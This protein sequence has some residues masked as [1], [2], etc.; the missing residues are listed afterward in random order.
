MEVVTGTFDPPKPLANKS[1]YDTQRLKAALKYTDCTLRHQERKLSPVGMH[2]LRLYKDACALL[3]DL[4]EGEAFDDKEELEV[5]K[6]EWIATIRTYEELIQFW[7]CLSTTRT[8]NAQQLQD[9]LLNLQRTSFYAR[10][11]DYLAEAC[12][13]L[14]NET[15]AKKV[16]GWQHLQKAYWTDSDKKLAGE[17]DAY[18]RVLAGEMAHAECQT[19]LAVRAACDRVGLEMNDILSAIYHYA[20]QNEEID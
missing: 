2:A 3:L 16:A 13:E 18:Q 19:H 17:K 9:E 8:S 12:R 15:E 1:D 7:A 6:K 20:L 14:K 5:A 4:E 11:G 10:Y